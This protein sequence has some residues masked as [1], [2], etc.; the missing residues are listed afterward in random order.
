MSIDV[1]LGSLDEFARDTKIN[2]KKLIEVEGNP[3]GNSI[4][5]IVYATA[6]SVVP[7]DA[8]RDIIVELAAQLDDKTIQAAKIAMATMS[9]NNIYYRF[10][11]LSEDDALMKMPAGLRMQ[12]MRQH[13]VDDVLFELMSLAVSALNGCGMCIQA[14]IQTLKKHDA[15]AEQIQM[16]GKVAGVVNALNQV[17][18]AA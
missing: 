6:I 12:S 16:A 3:L 15:T 11:H 10:T 5:S 1:V 17:T 4:L 9:M 8:M 14:H 7:S 2:F 18:M 13:D